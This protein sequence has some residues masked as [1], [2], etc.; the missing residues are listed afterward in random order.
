MKPNEPKPI[1]DKW[2]TPPDPDHYGSW[3]WSLHNGAAYLISLR[4]AG[5]SEEQVT[6]L[7]VVGDDVSYA[8]TDRTWARCPDD[9]IV[10]IHC[11]LDYYDGKTQYYSNQPPRVSRI[12]GDHGL[13]HFTEVKPRTS[14]AWYDNI[15]PTTCA[16]KSCITPEGENILKMIEGKAVPRG[17]HRFDH[18]QDIDQIVFEAKA[19]YQF[20]ILKAIH[21]SPVDYNAWR[22]HLKS[23]L[24]LAGQTVLPLEFE[25]ADIFCD[26]KLSPNE[27]RLEFV[28]WKDQQ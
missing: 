17:T 6:L 5:Y 2:M 26:T 8:T 12:V 20:R 16:F 1:L 21:L 27:L 3:R 7:A 28:N 24:P 22:R 23:M 14:D 18:I 25:R 4:Q 9:P 11:A 13:L 19:K 15:S 10:L